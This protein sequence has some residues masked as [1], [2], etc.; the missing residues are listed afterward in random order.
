MNNDKININS[1]FV[2][3]N[4][5][6]CVWMAAGVVSYKLCNLEFEC[7]HCA[8]DRIIRSK[9]SSEIVNGNYRTPNNEKT[10]N[11][12]DHAKMLIDKLVDSEINPTYYYSKNHI[13]FCK[14]EDD[15]VLI[16][17]DN[18]L[19]KILTYITCIVLMPV[20][21]LVRQKKSF[22]WFIQKDKTLTLYSPINGTVLQ[23]NSSL[24]NSPD[25]IRTTDLQKSWLTKIKLKNDSRLQDFY[26]GEE[27]KVW[28]QKELTRTK[29]TFCEIIEKHRPPISST[30]FDGGIFSTSL[31]EILPYVEYWKFLKN[32]CFLK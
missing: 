21:E 32:L 1:E 3:S 28:F 31:S 27:A 24:L 14:D 17:I 20:G 12:S 4:D 18:L 23:N 8:Y 26:T 16:G 10:V 2:S 19:A 9:I 25:H 30:Q 13:C 7:E 22:C 11:Y 5:A 15:V 6:K 29:D